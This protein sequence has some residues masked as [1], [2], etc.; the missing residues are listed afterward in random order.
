MMNAMMLYSPIMIGFMTYISPAGLGL[1]FFVGG[2]F[3]C[4]QTLI[5]VLMRPRIE[6]RLANEF[7]VIPP[8]P[9]AIPR[10]EP[11]VQQ[12]EQPS[13][14]SN[15]ERNAGKQHR[16]ASRVTPSQKEAPSNQPH[17]LSNRERNAGKQHRKE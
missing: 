16:Q 4:L 8:E 6:K 12:A 13:E 14:P 3:A 17:Q 2:I 7:E 5:I 15:R 9:I 10:E 11:T 1:Y